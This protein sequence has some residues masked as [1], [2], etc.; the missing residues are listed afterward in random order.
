M[1]RPV[2]S[3]QELV[4]RSFQWPPH[5]DALLTRMAQIMGVNKTSAVIIAV[6][7]LAEQKGI[8]TPSE[9]EE[10]TAHA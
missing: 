10:T 5:I 1:A 3:A 9:A 6:Q 8:I 2:G 7:T 4:K